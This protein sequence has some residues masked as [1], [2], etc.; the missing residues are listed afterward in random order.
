M[1]ALL[2]FLRKLQ[3][4]RAN[5]GWRIQ[6]I[7]PA[8]EGRP[9]MFVGSPWPILL[10]LLFLSF[11]AYIL[12]FPLVRAA[13]R[14][15]A[16]LGSVLNSISC[17][18]AGLLLLLGVPLLVAL[19]HTVSQRV[20]GRGPRWVEIEARCLDRDIQPVAEYRGRQTQEGWS[21]R[22]LCEF[23]FEG[24]TYRATPEG[25]AEMRWH[26]FPS[27]EAVAEFL[28][29]HIGPEGR[30]RLCINARNPR[31]CRLKK[32]PHAATLRS[33]SPAE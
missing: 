32:D 8:P 30:C 23:N 5:R 2:R 11:V 26:M 9:E 14:E 29:R 27:A 22:L 4:D 17:T 16:G 1:K 6:R 24:R 12:L 21:Y 28:E 18:F 15:G 19:A 7:N 10:A 20:R 33:P 3:D 25:Y 13:A 31:Q